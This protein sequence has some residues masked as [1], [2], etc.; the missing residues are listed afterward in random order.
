[1]IEKIYKI[2]NREEEETTKKRLKTLESHQGF[3]G[4]LPIRKSM[5]SHH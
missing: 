4:V 1:M 5:E 3:L 2:K